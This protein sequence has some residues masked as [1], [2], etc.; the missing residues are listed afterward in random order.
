MRKHTTMI[1]V[2]IILLLASGCSTPWIES[3]DEASS[4]SQL[5]TLSE[6]VQRTVTAMLQTNG[7]S[8]TSRA[9]ELRQESRALDQTQ[10]TAPQGSVEEATYADACALVDLEQSVVSDHQRGVS[11]PNTVTSQL[12][13]YLKKLQRNLRVYPK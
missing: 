12:S 3:K 13:A 6:Q 1:G 11:V 9:R 10:I 7:G 8:D 2:A 5:H 4:R